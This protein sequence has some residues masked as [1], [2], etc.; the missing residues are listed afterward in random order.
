MS[1]LVGHWTISIAVISDCLI[2]PDNHMKGKG[3]WIFSLQLVK[4][5]L[6]IQYTVL[7]LVRQSDGQ[8]P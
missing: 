2:T 8:G 3:S 1:H 5:G 7:G 4:D 6:Y